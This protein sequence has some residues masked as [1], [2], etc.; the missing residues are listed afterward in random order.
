VWGECP[1]LLACFLWGL[2]MASLQSECASGP[3]SSCRGSRRLGCK[4]ETFPLQNRGKRPQLCTLPLVNQTFSLCIRRCFYFSAAEDSK[5]PKSRLALCGLLLVSCQGSVPS[6]R[7]KCCPLQL[8]PLV[9]QC[10]MCQ[11]QEFL[12]ASLCPSASCLAGLPW[13]EL[14]SSVPYNHP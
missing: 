1:L 4:V 12:K 13:Q 14:L 7:D 9:I 6:P 5:V 2:G 11:A 3:Q 10:C 8:V